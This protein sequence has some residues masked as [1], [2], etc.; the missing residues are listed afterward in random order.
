M[1][2]SPRGHKQPAF[3]LFSQLRCKRTGAINTPAYQ[4]WIIDLEE[5]PDPRNPTKEIMKRSKEKAEAAAEAIGQLR[6]LVWGRLR[7]AM[8]T[9]H[10]NDQKQS[11]PSPIG[12]KRCLRPVPLNAVLVVVSYN[13][14]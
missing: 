4:T 6:G 1:L 5:D 10:V 14:S 8:G 12:H 9:V 2:S 13:T 7:V 11:G 3:V